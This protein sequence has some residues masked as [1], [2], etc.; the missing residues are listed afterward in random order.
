MKWW[1][2]E[3]ESWDP[4]AKLLRVFSVVIHHRIVYV[5]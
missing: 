1:G 2:I 5:N 3:G 4:F